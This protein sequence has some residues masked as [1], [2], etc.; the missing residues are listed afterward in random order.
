MAVEQPTKNKIPP[1]LDFRELNESVK[2]QTGD[3]MTDVCSEK[4]R[5][6]RQLEGD[7]E[8][9]DL[10]AAYLQIKVAEELW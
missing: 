7:R 5:E 4:L 3:D 2:C 9:V 8:M 10:K 1:V 6:R